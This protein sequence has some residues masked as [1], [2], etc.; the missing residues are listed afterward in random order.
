MTWLGRAEQSPLWSRPCP[1]I[2]KIFTWNF[3]SKVFF[4]SGKNTKNKFQQYSTNFGTLS[5]TVCHCI[6]SL[7]GFH[8]CRMLSPIEILTIT[9]SLFWKDLKS[10]PLTH[11]LDGRPTLITKASYTRKAQIT[12]QHSKCNR[13]VFTSNP[14]SMTEPFLTKLV[15]AQ[16]GTLIHLR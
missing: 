14:L 11:T 12:S 6:A 10:P 4:K 5:I 16:S 13:K 7:F 1:D 3:K 8:L 15:W 2:E 9:N